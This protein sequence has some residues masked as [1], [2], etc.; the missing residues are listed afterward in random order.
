MSGNGQGQQRMGEREYE[1]GG[2]EKEDICILD[3]R[4]MSASSRI[5]TGQHGERAF[6][7]GV[8]MPSYVTLLLG[9]ALSFISRL[10]GLFSSSY[11]RRTWTTLHRTK[12]ITH[13]YL[14]TPLDLRLPK[15][16]CK[17]AVKAGIRTVPS[18]SSSQRSAFFFFFLNCAGKPT[19]T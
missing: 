11:L 10:Q 15:A 3:V 7:S 4:I 13:T 18:P 6:V 14:L 9:L 17:N 8:I 2:E 1:N 5:T 12:T 19:E 16:Q